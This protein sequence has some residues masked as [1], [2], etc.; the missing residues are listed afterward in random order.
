MWAV[1]A[2]VIDSWIGPGAPTDSDVVQIWVERAERLLRTRVPDL[3]ARVDGYEEPE[4]RSTAVDVVVA[5]VTR[6]FRNPHGYRQVNVT[7]GPFSEGGTVGGDNPGSLWIT[8]EE[9]A[10]L[11]P[12]VAP[13]GAFE[14]DPLVGYVMPGVRDLDWS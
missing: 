11:R 6:V 12:S 13:G 5:M 9:L 10:Q 8:D 2:D 3:E 1:A 14:I 4:L 7:T